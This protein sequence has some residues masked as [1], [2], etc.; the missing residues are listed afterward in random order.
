MKPT[1]LID[2][3]QALPLEDGSFDMVLSFSTLEH[4]Y[5]LEATLAELTRVLKPG[6]RVVF[7]VPFLYRV[8]GCPDDYNRP[9][10]SWWQEN[11]SGRGFRNL[12][13]VPLVWDAMT[14]GLSVTEGVGPFK[15]L[16]RMLTPIYGLVYATLKAPKSAEFYP[17]ATGDLLASFALGYVITGEKH[18]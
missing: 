17:Q 7:A 16:R 18:V 1:Y 4:I 9:T 14:T 13:I 12:E 8:H 6:G 11:L 3:G 5:A 2:A 15:N 10:A